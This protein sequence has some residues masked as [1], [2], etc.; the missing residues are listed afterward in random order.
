MKSNNHPLEM[1]QHRDHVL[2]LTSLARADVISHDASAPTTHL[3]QYPGIVKGLMP[4]IRLTSS[5][6]S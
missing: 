6:R 2:D 3:P 4:Q 1:L 5:V